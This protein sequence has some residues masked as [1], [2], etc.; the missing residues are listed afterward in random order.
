M[1]TINL[2]TVG[3]IV[4]DNLLGIRSKD[5]DMSVTIPNEIGLSIDQGFGIMRDTLVKAGVT[6]WEDRPE[7]LTIRGGVAKDHPLAQFGSKDLDFVLARRDGPSRDGRRPDFVVVG[8]LADDLNRRDF[9][10]NA[11]A[12]K[13]GS[14]D[15][16]GEFTASPDVC[17]IIDPHRGIEDLANMTLRFVGDP[18]TRIAEDGLRVM[19]ALRFVV[20]KGFTMASETRDAIED[21]RSAVLLTS[22]SEERREGELSRMLGTNTLGTLDLFR[23]LPPHLME[24]MFSGRVRL[25]ATLRK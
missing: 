15:A 6:I 21:V 16:E 18:M 22:V 24:A 9:T 14:L 4:R 25:A 7:F 20:T 13:V 17:H 1:T 5:V 3:G 8:S 11:M 19:R 2:H 23:T 10:V 12:R